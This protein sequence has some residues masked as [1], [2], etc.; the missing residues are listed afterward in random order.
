MRSSMRILMAV[1]LVVCLGAAAMFF[2]KY[3]ES[4]TALA[5][6]QSE[7]ETTRGR[8][9]EAINSIATIQD[10]LNA[11]VLGRDAGHMTASSYETERTLTQSQGDQVLERIGLLRAGIERSKARI[12]ALDQNLRKS[13]MRIDGLERMIAGLR[14]SVAKKEE[15]I[16]QL[17]TQVDSLHTQVDG[18]TASNEEKRSELS[19]VFVLIGDKKSLRDAGAVV[20]EGGVLGIGK[21]LKPS[22]HVDETLCTTIDTDQQTEVDIPA[23]NARVLTPQP[24]AS[25]ALLPDGDHT[26]LRILD[27]KEFRKVRQLVIMTTAA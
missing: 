23:K 18:L 7:D 22:G 16:A 5:S 27:P 21:T 15:Q 3:Q 8:Y 4:K 12:E 17:A 26:V 14:R 19:T 13:G 11:I 1:A 2:M 25:Y 9:A 10:S 20:A 6:M 24:T